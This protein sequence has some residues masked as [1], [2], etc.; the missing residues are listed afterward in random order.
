M[1]PLYQILQEEPEVRKNLRGMKNNPKDTI[2]PMPDSRMSSLK[3]N[4]RDTISPT[5]NSGMSSLRNNP[6]DTISQDDI[7]SQYYDDSSYGKKKGGKINL[8]DCKVSTHEK[9]PKHKHCW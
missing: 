3:D 9:N 6:K 7:M 8:K 5:P 4:P 1:K 2:D